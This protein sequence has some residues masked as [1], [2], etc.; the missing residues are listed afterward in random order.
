MP[1]KLTVLF[2][3]ILKIDVNFIMNCCFVGSVSVT[4]LVRI[5]RYKYISQLGMAIRQIFG[6]D[7]DSNKNPSKKWQILDSSNILKGF[8]LN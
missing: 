1:N 3:F 2:Y 8:S 6:P 7:S 4:L 5:S